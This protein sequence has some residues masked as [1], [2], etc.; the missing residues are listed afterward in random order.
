[1]CSRPYL[2][3]PQSFCL[4]GYSAQK[5]TVL[6]PV[7]AEF[8]EGWC[9]KGCRRW[10]RLGA[11]SCWL[12]SWLDQS[13]PMAAAELCVKSPPTLLWLPVGKSTPLMSPG[14]LF[15]ALDSAAAVTVAAIYWVITVSKCW[16]CFGGNR[17]QNTED[18]FINWSLNSVLI[19][20]LQHLILRLS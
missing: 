15:A 10:E 12:G 5:W 1:M 17:T 14:W 4:V 7:P 13:L 2:S 18:P 20:V 11:G 9:D 16:K 8:K 3:P 6:G 19:V